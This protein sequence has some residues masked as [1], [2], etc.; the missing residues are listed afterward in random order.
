MEG[1]QEQRQ[2]SSTQASTPTGPAQAQS[3]DKKAGLKGLPYDQQMQKLAP[4]GG[5][6]ATAPKGPAAVD[7]DGGPGATVIRYEN[8]PRYGKPKPAVKVKVP[9][10]QQVQESQVASLKADIHDPEAPGA[11]GHLWYTWAQTGGPTYENTAG[12]YSPELKLQAPEV[13]NDE[14]IT[15]ELTVGKRGFIKP[16]AVETKKPF[17]VKVKNVEKPEAKAEAAPPT[18]APAAQAQTPLEDAPGKA[19][20]P[21]FG[22]FEALLGAALALDTPKEKEKVEP[23]PE[24]TTAPAKQEASTPTTAP[25]APTTAPAPTKEPEAPQAAAPEVGSEKETPAPAARPRVRRRRRHHHHR[26]HRHHHHHGPVRRPAP[27][28]RH[29]RLAHRHGEMLALVAQLLRLVS[30]INQRQQQPALPTTKDPLPKPPIKRPTWVPPKAPPKVAAPANKSLLSGERGT[31]GT[32]VVDPDQGKLGGPRIE[33][34]QTAAA[35]KLE[36]IKGQGTSQLEFKAPQVSK[37][38]TLKGIVHAT[39]ADGLTGQAP[40]TVTVEPVVAANEKGRVWG[41]PH[42]EGGDGGK[43]DVMGRDGGVYNLHSDTGVRVTGLFKTYKRQGITVVDRVGTIVTGKGPKGVTS[44]QIEYSPTVATIDGKPLA[45]NKS[46]PLADGGSALL[47]ANRLVIDTR[48]GYKVTIWQRA[49]SGVKYCDVD[50]QTGARGVGS[51]ADPGGL[52]GQTFDADKLAKNG[53]K[54]VGAQGEGAIAGVV[55]D[56]ETKGLFGAGTGK[57]AKGG[58]DAATDDRRLFRKTVLVAANPG[59]GAEGFVDSGLDVQPGDS[60]IISASGAA[61]EAKRLTRNPAGDPRYQH[62]QKSSFMAPGAP[63][64]ALVGRIAGEK[65]GFMVGPSFKGGVKKGGKLQLAF[66]DLRGTFGDNVGEYIADVQ[67]VKGKV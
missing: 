39:D 2:A 59:L 48:E 49:S 38:T 25:S 34:R 46:T 30:L 35:Q 4:D 14:L 1:Q 17:A 42:F 31:L 47:L 61:G 55:T 26:H 29:P 53:K 23:K 11:T 51:G 21:D 8:D 10:G 57:H 36:D 45:K 37:K 6:S 20:A 63:A 50:V 64:F 56:Y 12:M 32:T 52:L 66:N 44:N 58:L 28:P 13:E 7:D 67:V 15:G 43:F 27:K 3:G 65:T 22:M 54:G 16:R 9:D 41:D 19:K 40:F 33:W 24:P 18:P 62:K 5:A 60:V